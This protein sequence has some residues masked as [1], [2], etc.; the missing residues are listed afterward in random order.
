[1]RL[2]DDHNLGDCLSYIERSQ[3]HP[4]LLIFIF[5]IKGVEYTGVDQW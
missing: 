3:G 1:M 2:Q 4:G 5:N